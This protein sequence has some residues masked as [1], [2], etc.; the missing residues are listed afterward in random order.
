MYLGLSVDLSII[1]SLSADFGV[2]KG[3]IKAPL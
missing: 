3:L 1:L 2:Y